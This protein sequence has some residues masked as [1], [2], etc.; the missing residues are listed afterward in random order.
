MK[1]LIV[2]LY[3]YSH[4]DIQCELQFTTGQRNS[5]QLIFNDYTYVKN[6][7]TLSRIT[8]KC[9]RKVIIH[10]STKLS[11]SNACASLARHVVLSMFIHQIF[12]PNDRSFL[13]QPKV[14][15]KSGDR[16][17]QRRT[18]NRQCQRRS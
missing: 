5:T 8:W 4:I 1:L 14:S 13:G 12:S 3:F 2:V 16:H 15:C 18:E 11:I 9:S 7:T 10:Y 17:C 6:A